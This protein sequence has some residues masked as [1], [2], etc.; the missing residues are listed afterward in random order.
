M[1]DP[2]PRIERQSYLPGVRLADVA[3]GAAL[4][5]MTLL[6]FSPTLAAGYIWDDDRYISANPL[7]QSWNGLLRIWIDPGANPDYYPLTFTFLWIGRHLWGF[8]ATAYHL[9]NVL[10]HGLYNQ[11]AP[12]LVAAPTSRDHETLVL[13]IWSQQWPRLRRS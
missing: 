7:L 1:N 4:L 2:T 6:A 5:G 12:V 10:L 8:A 9:A 13:A 3:R 11:P